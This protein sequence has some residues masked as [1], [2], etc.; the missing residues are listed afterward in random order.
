MRSWS[1]DDDHTLFAG[2]DLDLHR[3][4]V[5]CMRKLLAEPADL[6]PIARATNTLIA[7]GVPASLNVST[8]WPISVK[9]GKEKPGSLNYARHHRCG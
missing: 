7:I 6:V 9:L 4:S 5:C 2:A 3:P 8:R 1:A